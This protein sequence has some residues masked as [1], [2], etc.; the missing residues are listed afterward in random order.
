MPPSQSLREQQ[1]REPTG[2]A[3]TH[4]RL[5]DRTWIANNPIS[6][7]ELERKP[8]TEGLEGNYDLRDHIPQYRKARVM[9]PNQDHT[10]LGI[11]NSGPIARSK[12]EKFWSRPSMLGD[13][14]SEFE[15]RPLEQLSGGMEAGRT[16][17]YARTLPARQGQVLY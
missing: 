1:S 15:T 2:R 4:A 3:V 12:T 9:Q 17:A 8:T 11:R 6:F 5:T 14:F 13:T 7:S 10:N 16:R